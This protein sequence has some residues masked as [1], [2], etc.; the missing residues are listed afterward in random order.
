MCTVLSFSLTTPV[1]PPMSIN[2]CYTSRRALPGG[3]GIIPLEE[4]RVEH[5]QKY[6]KAERHI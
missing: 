3:S 4:S 2:L 1:N 6:V 5:K